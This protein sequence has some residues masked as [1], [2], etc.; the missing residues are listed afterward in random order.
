MNEC[1]EGF[2]SVDMLSDLCDL[3]KRLLNLAK[4]EVD[5]DITNVDAKELGE[6][7]DMVKDLAAAEA[8]CYEACYYKTVVEA[9]ADA[10]TVPDV[11]DE[12]RRGYNHRHYANGRFAPSGRGMVMGYSPIMHQ[13]PYIDA[14]LNDPEFTSEMRRMGYDAAQDRNASRWTEHDPDVRGRTINHARDWQD[15]DMTER[16]YGKA[17]GDYL[18][19]R[20]HYTTSQSPEAREMMEQHAN[21][22]VAD[23]MNTIKDIYKSADPD[24]KKRLKA[25]LSKLV[26]EMT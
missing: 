18:K 11:D 15:S 20:R 21:E 2:K 9:M 25:D 16:R 23:T 5:R 6:V 3:K 8:S 22:H 10:E 4:G 13:N 19:A 1:F 17:Y 26:G 12:M 14:Y 7:V 24:Q